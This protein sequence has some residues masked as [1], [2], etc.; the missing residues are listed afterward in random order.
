MKNIF[1]KS[2]PLNITAELEM[3]DGS[4]RT[5]T[6]TEV[7]R[8]LMMYVWSHKILYLQCPKLELQL[9]LPVSGIFLE[10]KNLL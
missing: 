9:T 3:E 7:G 2:G 8:V 4:W 10:S 5:T 6:L 1:L